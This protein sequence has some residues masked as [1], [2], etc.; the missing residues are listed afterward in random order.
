[1]NPIEMEQLF[2]TYDSG[3]VGFVDGLFLKEKIRSFNLSEKV[4]FYF[5]ES[6]SDL[7]DDEM[8]SQVEFKRI[9]APYTLQANVGMFGKI[10]KK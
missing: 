3:N 7:A 10:G 6:I 9:F 1:M 2:E 4:L 8:L 5:M